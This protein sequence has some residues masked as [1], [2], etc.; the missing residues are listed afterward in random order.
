MWVTIFLLSVHSNKKFHEQQPHP[1][2]DI[3]IEN[4]FILQKNY[5]ITFACRVLLG[6]IDAAAG[7]N[8]NYECGR[9]L[10]EQSGLIQLGH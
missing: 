4:V 9:S 8:A 2:L 1:A 5:G 10:G 6:K 3:K 7:V